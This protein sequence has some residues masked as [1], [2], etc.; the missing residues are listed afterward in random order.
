MTGTDTSRKKI[1][2]LQHVRR[3][4]TG[5]PMRRSSGYLRV[6][7]EDCRGGERQEATFPKPENHDTLT[8]SSRS[9]TDESAKEGRR[10]QGREDCKKQLTEVRQMKA[11]EKKKR[12][13]LTRKRWPEHSKSPDAGVTCLLI[14]GEKEGSNKKRGRKAGA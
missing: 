8:E 1:G 4:D 5:R 3:T 12:R 14:L 2:V 9:P 10:A 7:A 13:V 11:T 6:K